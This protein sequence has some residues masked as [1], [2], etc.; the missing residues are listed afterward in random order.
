MVGVEPR[1]LL[2]CVLA[3]R[4]SRRLAPPDSFAGGEAPLHTSY[5]ADQVFAEMAAEGELSSKALTRLLALYDHKS[6]DA[7]LGLL[8]CLSP[9]RMP[10]LARS[11]FSC[12]KLLMR[13]GAP[14]QDKEWVQK[15]AAAMS[16]RS[17]FVVESSTPDHPYGLA[18]FVPCQLAV[19]APFVLLQEPASSCAAHECT[20]SSSLLSTLLPLPSVQE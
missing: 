8:V 1:C 16:G 18:P 5:I 2:C 19:R 14:R 9:P 3:R 17:F 13:G 15:L 12:C 11:P 20:V 6:L 4:L 7:A 10:V